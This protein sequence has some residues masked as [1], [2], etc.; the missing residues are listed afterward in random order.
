[1]KTVH[2]VLIIIICSG[3]TIL[4][5][6]ISDFEWLA[7]KWKLKS[8]NTESIEEWKL[9]DNELSGIS[10]LIIN[11]NKKTSEILYIKPI[12]GHVVYIAA[13]G[14]NRP[15][16]FTLIQN[17]NDKFVFENN[18]HD[19]PNRIIYNHISTDSLNVTIEGNNTDKKITFIFN[20]IQ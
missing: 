9:T 18:E 14:K 13:P 8:S 20:R 3:N 10:Y 16:L 15:T 6:N 2:F 17:E 4:A 5:Q 11:G 1:M 19:F 7:G 12:G